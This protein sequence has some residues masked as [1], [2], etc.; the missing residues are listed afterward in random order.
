MDK[1]YSDTKTSIAL[2]YVKIA[3]KTDKE[4]KEEVSLKVQLYR[5]ENKLTLEQFADKVGVS[6]MQI[7]RWEAMRSKPNQLAMEK[8]R[9]L[10]V[11]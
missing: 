5:K 8:L 9:A 1:F 10:K 4:I 6:K 7:I 2:H 11:I 3:K